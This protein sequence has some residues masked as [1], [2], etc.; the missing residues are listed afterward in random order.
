MKYIMF[1]NDKLLFSMYAPFLTPI[2]WRQDLILHRHM[3]S[4]TLVFSIYVF[5]PYDTLCPF[6]WKKKTHFSLFSISLMSCKI[7]I[8]IN[9]KPHLLRDQVIDVA[10]I[11]NY[12][13]LLFRFCLRPKLFFFFGQNLRIVG[14]ILGEKMDF[15]GIMK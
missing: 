9:A 12:L 10:C 7:S 1:W 4:W 5:F 13:N 6:P 3:F 15:K 11:A 8:L 14:M 2:F